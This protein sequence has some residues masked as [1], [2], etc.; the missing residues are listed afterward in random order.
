MGCQGLSRVNV[1]VLHDTGSF[2]YVTLLKYVTLPKYVYT[3]VFDGVS[4]AAKSE[5]G[6]LYSFQLSSTTYSMMRSQVTACLFE[7]SLVLLQKS[8]VYPKQ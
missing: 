5:F 7:K 6:E 4:G 3:G 2:L 8:P 1:C